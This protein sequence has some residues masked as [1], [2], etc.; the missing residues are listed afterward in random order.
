[1]FAARALKSALFGTPASA[2]DDTTVEIKT[3]KQRI[4][5]KDPRS[6]QRYSMSP[7]K[8]PGILLTPGT[9]T[10][11]R[12]TVSFGAELSDKNENNVQEQAEE[13][14]RQNMPQQN[15]ESSNKVPGKTSLTKSL[16]VARETKPGRRD[17]ERKRAS[18]RSQP[19]IDLGQDTKSFDKPAATRPT[20]AGSNP[21][22]T[23]NQDLLQELILGDEIDGDMTMDLNEPHS[24]SGKY[25]KSEY[26]QYHDEAKAEM[27]KLL[28]YK[29]LAKSYAK[30]KDAETLV[31]TAKLKEEQRRVAS[32]EDKISK[33]SGQKTMNGFGGNSDGSEELI[34]ELARQT[35]LARQYKAE[36]DGF[37]A[38]IKGGAGKGSAA[39]ESGIV[40]SRMQDI[41][42]D[43]CRDL[44]TT[45]EQ[46]RDLASLRN[47]MG[48]LR[49]TLSAAQTANS[50]LREENSMLT[51][52]LLDAN[53]R[54]E[55]QERKP[56]KHRQAT[57]EQLQRK[58]EAYESLQRDYDI[59]KEKAMAQRGNAEHLLRKEH[60]QVVGLRKE[61]KSMRRAEL[62]RKGIPE[63]PQKKPL[64]Y[65]LTAMGQEKE[66]THLRESG[67]ASDK[68]TD[69][70]ELKPR[71]ER[72][73]FDSE[74]K[75][76]HSTNVSNSRDS[77]IP[78]LSQSI[79]DSSRSPT[80]LRHINM[81]ASD[82][83]SDRQSLHIALSEIT[84]NA[85]TERLS[86]KRPN[87][88]EPTPPNSRISNIPRETPSIELPSPEPSL[89][90]ITDRIVPSRKFKPSPRPSMFTFAS[91]PPKPDIARPRAS[92][93]VS[94]KRA[95]GNL[96]R[97]SDMHVASTRLPSL[98]GSRTRTT[99]PPERAAAARA[100]LE[101]RN[102]EKKRLLAQGTG[103]E[104][105]LN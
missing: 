1:M 88:T 98:E 19:L 102:A 12:K 27:Q 2:A 3:E 5:D 14:R 79:S 42:T 103:K 49:Q 84:N 59:L 68:R 29:Q 38:T 46:L 77:H 96:G 78:V 30:K 95:D 32:L 4:T 41:I 40:P 99:L 35:A 61:L 58:I 90:R 101:K 18:S 97:G 65:E 73:E 70:V 85:R 43:T 37:R 24:Q 83:S 55:E 11:R 63:H 53:L 60:D 62:W 69:T 6:S 104:N 105:I 76:R 45:Q 31:L 13:K 22:Q 100:R 92:D 86:S 66:T 17:G 72:N 87:P 57:E 25:W 82:R 34:K 50:K 47:E 9:A 20:T 36:A 81:E 28:R 8:P 16:E 52:E 93:K 71:N 80:Y 91:S 94:E 7:T 89:L 10:A 23:S 56:E 54:L 15:E 39:C 21:L 64:E 74:T 75:Y 26:E 51:Q 44:R 33:L 48:D 67:Q